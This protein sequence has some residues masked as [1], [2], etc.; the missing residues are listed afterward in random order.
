MSSRKRKKDDV[1]AFCTHLYDDDGVDPR[2][3]QRAEPEYE[4]KPDRKLRQLCKQVAQTVELALAA[5]PRADMFVGVSVAAVTPAPHAGRLRVAIAGCL[6]GCEAEVV[7]VLQQYARRLRREVALTITRRRAPELT[8][9]VIAK[10]GG[11]G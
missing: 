9:E 3:D 4:N 2:T 10:G 11:D 5:L 8:F 6:P 1:R 7:A